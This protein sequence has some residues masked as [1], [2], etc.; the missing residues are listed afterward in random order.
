MLD[1]F[2][3][4]TLFGKIRLVFGL[5]NISCRTVSITFLHVYEAK[6][7]VGLDETRNAIEKVMFFIYERF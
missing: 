2:L 1:T 6:S 7:Q 5:L 4:L 3:S